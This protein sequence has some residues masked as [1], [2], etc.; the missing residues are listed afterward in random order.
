MSTQFNCQKHLFQAIQLI[1]TDLI[2]VSISTQLNVKQFYIKQF[3][4]V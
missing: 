2:Q 1:K 4:L 3:C